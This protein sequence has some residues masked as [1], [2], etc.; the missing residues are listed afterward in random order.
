MNEVKELLIAIMERYSRAVEEL[1]GEIGEYVSYYSILLLAGILVALAW[2]LLAL[3]MPVWY[4][5][6]KYFSKNNLEK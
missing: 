4:L 2:F 6:Y 1:L 3:T 5:P